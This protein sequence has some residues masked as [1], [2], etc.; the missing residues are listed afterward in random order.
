MAEELE[1][2]KCYNKKRESNLVNFQ[3]ESNGIMI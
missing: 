2:V 1:D 3:K